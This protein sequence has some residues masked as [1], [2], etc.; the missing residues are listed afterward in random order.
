MILM[1][2]SATAD[3]VCNKNTCPNNGVSLDLLL[4]ILAI[5]ISVSTAYVQYKESRKLTTTNLEATFYKDLYFDY[6]LKK[7][8]MARQEIRYNEQK[9]LDVDTLV[10]VLN[11]MRQDSLFFKYKDKSFYEQLKRHL[12]GLE[13]FLVGTSEQIYD[14]DDFATVHNNINRMIEEIYDCIMKKYNGY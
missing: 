12:Q 14:M 8:P 13:D 10:D 9:I 11:K 1:A 2:L 6:L 3:I 4:S 5:I 7:I